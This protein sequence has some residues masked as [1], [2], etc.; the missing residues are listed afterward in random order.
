MSSIVSRVYSAN[1]KLF[2]I[3]CLIFGSA[4]STTKQPK[5]T[6]AVNLSGQVYSPTAYDDT[7]EADVSKSFEQLEVRRDVYQRGSVISHVV[8]GTSGVPVIPA[9]GTITAAEFLGGFLDLNGV[10]STLP[11][12]DLLLKAQPNL[13]VGSVLSCRVVNLH[14]TATASL[15]K[16]ANSTIIGVSGVNVAPVGAQQV[17]VVYT[18]KAVA[19]T[20]T[21]YVT[22]KTRQIP[23]KAL[24]NGGGSISAV[25]GGATPLTWTM[26]MSGQAIFLDCS[27]AYAANLPAVTGGTAN[28][29]GCVAYLIVSVGGS[30]LTVKGADTLDGIQ[31]LG[32][33]NRAANTAIVLSNSKPGDYIKVM[34]A[35]TTQG[36]LAYQVIEAWGSWA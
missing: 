21:A 29:V 22:I 34:C 12:A 35:L 8:T 14:A 18:I 33:S 30:T 17:E 27:S 4:T 6:T 31:G 1:R 5:M 16:G 3:L 26:A 28:K 23:T 19:T 11:D 9:S 7:F 25:D 2:S 10:A 24:V 36:V 15:T 32:I 20:G 13:H